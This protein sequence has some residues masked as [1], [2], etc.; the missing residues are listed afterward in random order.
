MKIVEGAAKSRQIVEE[1]AQL[2][3]KVGEATK[4]SPKD[5]EKMLE[6]LK[7]DGD[8]IWWLRCYI[9]SLCQR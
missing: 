2:P 7:K 3:Q 5:T 8:I 1:R 4:L 6:E 9:W